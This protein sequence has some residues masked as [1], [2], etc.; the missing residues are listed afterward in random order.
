LET[1]F[2]ADHACDQ[3]GKKKQFG[4]KTDLANMISKHDKTTFDELRLSAEKAF[5]K[6]V[7]S[8]GFHQ[9]SGRDCSMSSGPS[10]SVELYPITWGYLLP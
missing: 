3:L 5:E 7:L 4:R 6:R 10:S 9:P 8:I 1:L 2:D